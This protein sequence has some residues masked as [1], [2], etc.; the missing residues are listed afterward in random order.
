MSPGGLVKKLLLKPGQKAVVLNPPPGYLEALGELPEV[1]G[2]VARPSAALDFVHL[3]I[4]DRA[5]LANQVPGAL[6]L[7]KEDGVFWISYPKGSSC[8]RSDLNRDIL[9]KLMDRL[10]FKGVA[11]VSIDDDWSAMRFRP[12]DRIGKKRRS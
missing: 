9:W 4:R 3:F 8:I 12:G 11:M 2:M 7:I 1:A 5:E 10:G 6:R